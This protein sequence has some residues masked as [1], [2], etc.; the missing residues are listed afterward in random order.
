MTVFAEQQLNKN[1]IDALDV[2]YQRAEPLM[3]TAHGHQFIVMKAE[4]YFG[5]M[6]T[7]HLLSSAKNAEML[8]Q[9]MNEPL[10]QCRSAAL[11]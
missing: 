9:A 10:E 7:E 8:E 6:K 2:L 4:D 3:F 1:V 11:L 5:L